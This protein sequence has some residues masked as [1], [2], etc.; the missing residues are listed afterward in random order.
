MESAPGISARSR[1]SVPAPEAVTS[2]FLPFSPT[3]RNFRQ[4]LSPMR[5]D[6]LKASETA[7][8]PD[9]AIAALQRGNKI[10]AIKALRIGRNMGLKE[11]KAM[12]DDY[13]LGRPEL[14]Q[15][16]AA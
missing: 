6:S 9:A 14:Q 11:A 2:A 12:V 13:V 10:A 15:S 4:E 3:A 1:P 7:T 16:V 5:T 8:L